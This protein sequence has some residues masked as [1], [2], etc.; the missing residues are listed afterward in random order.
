MTDRKLAILAMTAVIMAGWAI[1]QSRLLRQTDSTGLFQ[2]APLIQGMNIDAVAQISVLSEKGANSL[3]LN[4]QDGRFQVLEKDGYPANVS[5]INTLLNNCLDIRVTDRITSNPANHVD[6]GVT[7]D[8]A[9]YSV[10]FLNA[11]G[12]EITGVLISGQQAEREGA[13]VRLTTS[14]ETYFVQSPPWISTTPLSYVNTTLIEIDRS[15]IRQVEVRG[16]QGDYVLMA[17]DGGDVVLEAMPEGKQFKGTAY[18]S[19]FG[20]L[21]SVRF[22]DVM[23]AGSAPD[24]LV[25]TRRF[26][27]QMEDSTVYRVRLAHSDNKYYATISA[28]FLDQTPVQ[29]GRTES[30]EELKKKEAK[31]LAMDAAQAFAQRHK[32]WVYVIASWKAEDLTKTLDDLLEEAV[33]PAEKEVET[34][35]AAEESGPGEE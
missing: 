23:A 17:G 35:A 31:L 32:G 18:Q 21:G 26:V 4:K 10:R 9:Q 29:V 28:E 14:D 13:Y 19:V 16:P 11:A 2:S 3:T 15:K 27:C 34:I 33:E 20:A 25:F 1:L 6:L 12:D 8:T 24:D 7:D 30:E 22:E 5:A